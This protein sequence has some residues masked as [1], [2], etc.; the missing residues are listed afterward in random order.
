MKQ[1]DN[2]WFDNFAFDEL[3]SVLNLS[4]RGLSK[5]TYT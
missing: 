2:S 3:G 1:G 4:L 5:E